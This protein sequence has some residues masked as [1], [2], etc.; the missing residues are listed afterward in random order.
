MLRL[1]TTAERRQLGENQG[2]GDVLVVGENGGLRRDERQNAALFLERK[3]IPG[4]G[5]LGCGIVR[6]SRRLPTSRSRLDGEPYEM[7]SRKPVDGG[8]IRLLTMRRPACGEVPELG[9]FLRWTGHRCD[10]REAAM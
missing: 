8:T 5:S 6:R 2:I 9:D 7:D 10:T 1:G 4:Q 3:K